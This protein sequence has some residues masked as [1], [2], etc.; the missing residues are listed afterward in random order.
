MFCLY[1]AVK[2]H[3]RNK[4]EKTKIISDITVSLENKS[5][6]ETPEIEKETIEIKEDEK[7][8]YKKR[9]EKSY[10]NYKNLIKGKKTHTVASFLHACIDLE[11]M[12]SIYDFEKKFENYDECRKE[13]LLMGDYEFY[14]KQGIALYNELRKDGVYTTRRAT[15][16]ND[17]HLI[18]E[19]L[20]ITN[21]TPYII[22]A[23]NNHE[24][25]WDNELTKYKR[26]STY[27][28]QIDYLINHT[29]ELL[30]K[31]YVKDNRMAQ[32][33]I[34]Q[35]QQKYIQMRNKA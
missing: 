19:H 6:Y 1:M 8:S 35:L 28:N 31:W 9:R 29:T 18:T 14:I 26:K 27:L 12:P 20:N 13:L 32:Q 5:I 25:Y 2:I 30:Q 16:K 22:Q 21:R 24:A 4:K 34:L 10:D 33:K 17:A 7:T 11:S 15:I 23:C 3:K